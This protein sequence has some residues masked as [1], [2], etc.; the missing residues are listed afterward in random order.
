MKSPAYQSSTTTETLVWALFIGGMTPWRAFW[1]ALPVPYF[2]K[3]VLFFTPVRVRTHGAE[4][5]AFALVGLVHAGFEL[6]DEGDINC[7]G[8]HWETVL[9]MEI[10]DRSTVVPERAGEASWS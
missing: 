10:D 8:W 4:D 9:I 3:V 1:V 7:R 2:W 5:R 6:F